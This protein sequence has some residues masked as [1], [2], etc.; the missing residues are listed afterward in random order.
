MNFHEPWLRFEG[1]IHGDGVAS[2]RV[3]A[4]ARRGK[5]TGWYGREELES[6]EGGS[7]RG[8]N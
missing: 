6:G 8:V 7:E 3:A 1:H 5:G 2:L 4:V